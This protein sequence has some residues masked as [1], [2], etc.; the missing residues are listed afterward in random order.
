M[1]STHTKRMAALFDG[2]E[3]DAAAGIACDDRRS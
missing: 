2:I 3:P 1:I